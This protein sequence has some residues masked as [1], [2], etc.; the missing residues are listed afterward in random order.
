MTEEHTPTKPALDTDKPRF[1][2][3]DMRVEVALAKYY[4]LGE[5]SEGWNYGEIAE[6]LRVD[7]STVRK[8]I[9]ETELAR[10]VEEKLADRQARTRMKI[11]MKLL[12]RVDRLEE[13][14]RIKEQETRPAVASHR[15]E[16]VEGTVRMYKDGME[17]DDETPM[18]FEVP[19][20]DQFVEVPKIDNDLKTLYK[21][22]RMTIQEVEDLM[23]LEAP[24]KM[25]SEH[26]E[27]NAQIKQW[28]VDMGDAEF[29]EAEVRQHEPNPNYEEEITVEKKQD[30]EE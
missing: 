29:P 28:N 26:R 21:E 15:Y 4:G 5:D 22:W 2:K 19:V 12:D 11:A 18:R 17:V 14:I 27:I 3:K 6:Y 9:H 30:E 8:Y 1:R 13:Q 25:E 24:E 23:G 10:E 16:Q 20:P 7:E